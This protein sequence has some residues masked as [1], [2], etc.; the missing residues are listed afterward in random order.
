LTTALNESFK[1]AIKDAYG[2][3]TADLKRKTRQ[4]FRTATVEK[5]FEKCVAEKLGD[6]VEIKDHAREG[7]RVVER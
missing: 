2:N 4:E 3:R 6:A 1:E 7:D 5:M